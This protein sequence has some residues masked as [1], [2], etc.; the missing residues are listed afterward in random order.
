LSTAVRYCPVLL[1]GSLSPGS[2]HGH[3]RMERLTRFAG[4]NR[5]ALRLVVAAFAIADMG[6]SGRRVRVC[7]AAVLDW[8]KRHPRLCNAR[9]PDR[10]AY[11]L[12]QQVDGSHAFYTT[13]P[14]QSE[15]TLQPGEVVTLTF[16]GQVFV[17]RRPR[18]MASSWSASMRLLTAACATNSEPWNVPGYR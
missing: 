12:R 2:S 11:P 17:T 15:V 7:A 6:P 8:A 10:R 18:R 16:H 5:R 1:V 3:E 4:A 14:V 9:Q 13:N